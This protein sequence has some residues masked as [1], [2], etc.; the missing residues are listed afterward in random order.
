MSVNVTSNEVYALITTHH[1]FIDQFHYIPL[2]SELTCE[3]DA[4]SSERKITSIF[5][6]NKEGLSDAQNFSTALLSNY[7]EG[8]FLNGPRL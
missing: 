7:G 8:L 3:I 6:K 5:V 2:Q 4:N 1:V